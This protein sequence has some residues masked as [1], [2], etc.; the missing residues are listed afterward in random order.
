MNGVSQNIDRDFINS[1]R[2][3][4]EQ[5]F[6]FLTGHFKCTPP[7]VEEASHEWLVYSESKGVVFC[8]PCRLFP[9]RELHPYHGEEVCAPHYDLESYAGGSLSYWQGHPSQTGRRAGAR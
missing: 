1:R 7:N 2:H 5:V 4:S 6:Y 3:Y 9:P 8:V